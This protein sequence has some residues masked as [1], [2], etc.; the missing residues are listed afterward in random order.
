MGLRIKEVFEKAGSENLALVKDG[1][2]FYLVLNT[3]LNLLE[4]Q[5]LIKYADLLREIEEYQGEAVLVTIGSGPKVFSA[6]FD[7]NWWKKAPENK[8]NTL[9]MAQVLLA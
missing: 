5:M 2:I 3:K 4:P 9:D 6:G 8:Q 7:L 1:N